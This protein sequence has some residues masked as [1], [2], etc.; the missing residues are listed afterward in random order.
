M[1]SPSLMGRSSPAG[2]TQ[3][4]VPP[5]CC[6]ASAMADPR[7][8]SR[9]S[10]ASCLP[11]QAGVNAQLRTGLGIRCLPHSPR[12]RWDRGAGARLTRRPREA[13]RRAPISAIPW[14]QW[15][16]GLFGAFYI[17]AAV[18]LAPRLG[19]AALIASIVAG[20]M[21]ASLVLDTRGWAGFAQQPLTAQP[22]VWRPAGHRRGAADQSQVVPFTVSLFPVPRSFPHLEV[23]WPATPGSSSSRRRPASSDSPRSWRGGSLVVRRA[24]TPPRCSWRPRSSAPWP[25]RTSTCRTGWHP[26]SAVSPCRPATSTPASVPPVEAAAGRLSGRS[27]P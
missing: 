12:L 27:M 20:Q 24:T 5:P 13:L 21:I 1:T 9:F 10:S 14:Y 16:G 17:A 3:P 26:G 19:A 22:A 23:P 6:A 25:P 2:S 15:T 4:G 7:A 18:V 8:S 11:V